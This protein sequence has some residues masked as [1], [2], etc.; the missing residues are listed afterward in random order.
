MARI[1]EINVQLKQLD[2]DFRD[3]KMNGDEYTDKRQN[4]KR[5]K[6]SLKEE[7]VRMGVV[8]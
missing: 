3:E 1:S 5:T 2:S 4:L 6:D 7:L 8:T